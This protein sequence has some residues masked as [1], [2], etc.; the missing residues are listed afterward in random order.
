MQT[1]LSLP[2]NLLTTYNAI[3]R[4][5]QASFFIESDPQGSHL[6]SGGG[7]AW[8][9]KQFAKSHDF[10]QK[11]ILIHAGGQGRRLP[12]YSASGK[13]LHQ[14]LFIAGKLGRKSIRLCSIFRPTF[15]MM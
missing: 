5:S 12:S 9:L 10:N 6:G 3:C 4:P 1:L 8:I 15:I 14:F 13:I 2:Q 11:K 7:T